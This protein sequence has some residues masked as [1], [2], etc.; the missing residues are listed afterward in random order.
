MPHRWSRRQ[1]VQ[2]AG[3]VG[4]GLLAG[5]GLPF[6]KAEPPTSTPR[7]GYFGSSAREMLTPPEPGAAE[8]VDGFLEGLRDLGHEEGRSYTL[9]WRQTDQG[10]ERQRAFAAEL[11]RLPADVIVVGAGSGRLAAEATATIPIV[12]FGGPD[13]VAAGLAASYA[14]PGGNVTG[15]PAAPSGPFEGKLLELLKEASPGLSRVAILFDAIQPMPPLEPE[16]A[17]GAGARTLGLDLHPVGVRSAGELPAALDAVVRAGADGLVFFQTGLL[18]GGRQ[19]EVASLALGHGLPSMGLFRNYAAAGG[20]MT[21]GTSLRAMGRRVAAYVDKILKG[22]SP[23]T[24]P[25][26]QPREFDFII[27]AKTAQALGLTIPQHVLL[28][29]TEVIQ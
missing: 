13:P 28:Q 22:A 10:D 9:V 18:G 17:L 21:Y 29:A 14:R 12:L 5:C 24:L 27:N 16:G 8:T 15:V 6:R 11:V 26:E 2:G 20:L 1:V 4:L 23:A 3:A 19:A 7:V 25:I